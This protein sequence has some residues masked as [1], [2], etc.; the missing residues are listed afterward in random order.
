MTHLSH[1]SSRQMKPYFILVDMWIN[2][3]IN[4]GEL[5]TQWLLIH[6][7]P[8]HA[9]SYGL[10]WHN[11]WKNHWPVLFWGWL[12]VACCSHRTQIPKNDREI[13][14]AANSRLTHAKLL[15]PARWGNGTY[16][17]GNYDITEG[18]LSWSFKYPVLVMFH[19]WPPRSPDFLI[20]FFGAIFKEKFIVLVPIISR[21]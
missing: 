3:I 11:K 2:W 6:K 13:F 10:V 9:E 17:K 5:K 15:V 20:S 4:Y 16:D 12:A 1:I 19:A 21:K 18:S 7:Q 14:I 8:T